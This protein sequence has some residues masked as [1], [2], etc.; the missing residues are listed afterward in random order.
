MLETHRSSTVPETPAITP[1]D[2]MPSAADLMSLALPPSRV[3]CGVEARSKKHALELIGELLTEPEDELTASDLF[4][5]LIQRER[6]GCT[7]LGH[8]VALPHGRS[9]MIKEPRAALIRLRE[10]VDYD[11]ADGA[12]VDLMLAILIPV[13]ADESQ[14]EMLQAA[15]HRLSRSSE[16][17]ALHRANDPGGLRGALLAPLGSASSTGS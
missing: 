7:G 12:P 2:S 1:V 8:G 4:C 3:R 16:R 6:L 10:A 17:A 15:A 9:A 13:D 11:A 5:S 14:M